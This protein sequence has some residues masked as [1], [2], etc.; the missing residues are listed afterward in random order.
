MSTCTGRRSKKVRCLF[1]RSMNWSSRPSPPTGSLPLIDP[2]AEVAIT[3]STP[4]SL[5]ARRLALKL[6][7]CGGIEWSG[8]CRGRN[9]NSRPAAVQGYILASP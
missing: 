1:D 9:R 6:M 3:R 7:R 4:A 8:P 2:T 5:S